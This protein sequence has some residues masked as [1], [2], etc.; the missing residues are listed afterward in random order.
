M[1]TKILT[2]GLADS[3]TTAAKVAAGAIVQVA[4]VVNS[5]SGAML[6][7]GMPNLALPT[8]AQGTEFLSLSFTPKAVTN[9]VLV[10]AELVGS[11]GVLDAVTLTVWRGTNY[12][13]GS[14][15]ILNAISPGPI[16]AILLDTPG[17]V[18]PVLYTVRGGG[19][20]YS[21]YLNGNS[22]GRYSAVVSSLTLLEVKA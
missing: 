16:I 4:Q 13:T 18:S 2:S 15:A 1:L 9:K 10:I 19:S 17:T 20:A 22:S 21:V 12:V 11:P 5:T 8:K 6:A 7:S 3:A 14:S